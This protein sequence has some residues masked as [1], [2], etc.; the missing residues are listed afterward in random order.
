MMAPPKTPK[1]P[2]G[3]HLP[4]LLLL[5]LLL[6]L[7]ISQ[8]LAAQPHTITTSAEIQSPM[9]D[10]APGSNINTHLLPPLQRTLAITMA[11][12]DAP[13][14]LPTPRRILQATPENFRQ[15][16]RQLQ[17][18]DRLELAPGTYSGQLN[19]H[20]IQGTAE[21]PIVITGPETGT[22]ALLQAR[23][24]QRTISL[25]NAAH[26]TIRHLTLD[27][28]QQN[29]DAIVAE[30]HSHFTHHITLEHLHIHNYDGAQ[31]H[32][33]ITTRSPAW[34]WIIRHNHIHHVGTGMYLGRPDGSGPFIGG[35]IEHNLIEDTLGYNAQI[36][37]QTQ[38]QWLPG[39][40]T[41]P[42]HTLIRYNTFSKARHG[43]SGNQARPNLL[44]GHFPETGLGQHDRYLI[45]GNLFYQNPYER[46]F[47]GEGNIALYNNLFVNHYNDAL[48]VRPHN[49]LPRE[50]HI[51]QNT[52]V[53]QGFGIHVDRPQQGYEQ[54]VAGNAVF[55]GTPLILPRRV[56]NK[57]NLTRNMGQADIY[58]R[59]PWG[60]LDTLD[61]RPV[62]GKLDRG[63]TREQEWEFPH[64]EWDFQPSDTTSTHLRRP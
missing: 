14:T 40:P 7:P 5:L 50:V 17:P 34:G 9:K 32:N 63:Q 11:E 41:Q 21:H 24:N 37:H 13:T 30:S 54:V 31:G 43:N 58:L 29:A 16:A 39:M 60:N 47:Q 57:D 15:L 44:V 48:I 56:R 45:H 53:A 20:H 23:N 3:H 27:G 49:H 22:P 64:L 4:P 38:R 2:T 42:G 12:P 36:K 1:H 52:L 55:A 6:L 51:L 46:L 19:L 35:L 8:P 18:G 26:I 33:G 10:S 25:V 28:Q 61:L 59:N 62:E